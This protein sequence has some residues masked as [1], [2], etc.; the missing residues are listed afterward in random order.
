MK[1]IIV[2]LHIMT[3]LK[4]QRRIQQKYAAECWFA[5]PA[6][7]GLKN[8]LRPVV[9]SKILHFQKYPSLKRWTISQNFIVMFSFPITFITS[10]ISLES[11]GYVVLK[12]WMLFR[13]ERGADGGFTSSFSFTENVQSLVSSAIGL[14]KH[15]RIVLLLAVPSA[16]SFRCVLLDSLS[17]LCSH[18]F[19]RLCLVIVCHLVSLSLLFSASFTHPNLYTKITNR[20]HCPACFCVL[21]GNL[22]LVLSKRTI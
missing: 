14:S 22:Y 19:F 9:H 7:C 6:S 20:G 2:N 17:A 4:K 10:A 18:F 11:S 12:T 21:G 13:M 8:W 15:W 3:V 1:Y 16:L 5:L